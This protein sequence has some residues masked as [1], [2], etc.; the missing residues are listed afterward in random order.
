MSKY[1]TEKT[2]RTIQIMNA[3]NR[4]Q[5]GRRYWI[6]LVCS[7]AI[8]YHAY[9][10]MRLSADA[11][12]ANS[13]LQEV[14]EQLELANAYFGTNITL[15]E[16]YDFQRISVDRSIIYYEHYKSLLKI[17][18]SNIF[19]P[20]I[21]E[22]L[23]KELYEEYSP[24]PITA[25]IFDYYKEVALLILKYMCENLDYDTFM[26]KLLDIKIIPNQRPLDGEILKN[27]IKTGEKWKKR[28]MEIFDEERSKGN[29]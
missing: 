10:S 12:N 14:E 24:I 16:V 28:Y 15:S 2:L 1:I 23:C 21:V 13:T 6:E 20:H 29:I 3:N 4:H 5:I 17:L 25:V 7:I 26:R 18:A 11:S 22:I 27:M 19:K 8:A 9:S